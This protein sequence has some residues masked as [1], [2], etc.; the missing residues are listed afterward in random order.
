MDSGVVQSIDGSLGARL[1]VRGTAEKAIERHNSLY[2]LS[3]R[4]F[5]LHVAHF[6]NTLIFLFAAIIPFFDISTQW[7][8]FCKARIHREDASEGQVMGSAGIRAVDTVLS[9]LAR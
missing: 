1:C 6:S 2:E 3:S 5:N 9:V 4:L 8:E 7:S